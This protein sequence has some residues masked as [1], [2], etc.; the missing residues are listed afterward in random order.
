M[1]VEKINTK[2]LYND[3]EKRQRFALAMKMQRKRHPIFSFEIH[4]ENSG[5]I[6]N[7]VKIFLDGVIEGLPLK[8]G[9]KISNIFNRIGAFSAWCIPLRRHFLEKD[10][11]MCSANSPSPDKN[12]IACDGFPQPEQPCPIKNS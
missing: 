1:K 5:K 11:V 12:F 6:V 4:D 2:N 9:Q 3:K 7:E 8:Q 10:S